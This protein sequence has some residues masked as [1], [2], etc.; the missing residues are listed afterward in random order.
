MKTEL[1]LT[2][3]IDNYNDQEKADEAVACFHAAEVACHNLGLSKLKSV[4]PNQQTLKIYGPMDKIHQLF[5]AL[6]SRFNLE[7]LSNG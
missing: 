1:I 7:E 5:V 2:V 6:A 3:K 4:H